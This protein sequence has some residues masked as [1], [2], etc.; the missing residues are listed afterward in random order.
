MFRDTLKMIF[1]ISHQGDTIWN[2]IMIIT[3]YQLEWLI[4]NPRII[5]MVQYKS[6]IRI[7]NMGITFHP[8]LVDLQTSII[9]MNINMMVPQKTKLFYSKIQLYH[10]W[11]YALKFLLCCHR[12]TWPTIFI[13]PLFIIVRNCKQH[14]CLSTEKMDLEM[15]YNYPMK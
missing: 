2:Y 9:R 8:F 1:I 10:F 11:A 4:L 6:F 3:F 14:R 5:Y 12:D 13:A 15:W 7:W